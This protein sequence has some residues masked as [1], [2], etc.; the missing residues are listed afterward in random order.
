LEKAP[1]AR[2]RTLPESCDQCGRQLGEAGFIFD[3][4]TTENLAWSWM[5]PACFFELGC[6]IGEGFGQLYLD[7]RDVTYL[8]L[9]YGSH[10]G[11]CSAS[12]TEDFA[13]AIPRSATLAEGIDGRND[14]P[15]QAPGKSPRL[16][17]R[18]KGFQPV[19]SKQPYGS[20]Q[21]Q[22]EI[23][24]QAMKNAFRPRYDGQVANK[25]LVYLRQRRSRRLSI[26]LLG[27]PRSPSWCSQSCA[28]TPL[29][30]SL[31]S[32]CISRA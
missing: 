12:T 16:P 5:C 24:Y 28:R 27:R 10:D 1:R 19:S 3:A 20:P 13:Q 15:L 11:T 30:L 31:I 14:G 18:L 17:R 23:E 8:I 32:P 2:L 7:G 6:G 22:D 9:G 26:G 29:K 25:L 21:W 4:C